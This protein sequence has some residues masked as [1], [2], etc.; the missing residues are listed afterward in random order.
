MEPKKEDTNLSTS[1]FKQ[2]P[3]TQVFIRFLSLVRVLA[4]VLEPFYVNSVFLVSRKRFF[5][6][7]L[8][9][10]REFS[11][12]LVN[13]NINKTK[14]YPILQQ[15]GIDPS[16]TH[17]HKKV[18]QDKKDIRSWSYGD[19]NYYLVV[20]DVNSVKLSDIIKWIRVCLTDKAAIYALMPILVNDGDDLVARFFSFFYKKNGKEK[21][22]L[23]FFFLPLLCPLFF[24]GGKASERYVS[25]GGQVI[26][27]KEVSPISILNSLEMK[28]Y[29]Q[30]NTKL[31][32][33]W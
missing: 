6:K 24:R 27:T 21:K 15:L 4:E 9:K 25:I 20:Y 11:S 1:C 19:M 26:I 30:V 12:T 18:L 32:Y 23:F 16:F 22:S 31:R 3:E 10:K 14:N 17:I 5:N 29:K 33:E 7:M 8:E 13:T 2:L 28:L